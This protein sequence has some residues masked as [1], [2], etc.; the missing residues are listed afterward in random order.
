MKTLRSK[1]H[2]KYNFVIKHKASNY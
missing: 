1:I 2:T